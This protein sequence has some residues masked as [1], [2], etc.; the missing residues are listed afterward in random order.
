M[1]Y[2]YIFIKKTTIIIPLSYL[3]CII[4]SVKYIR[5]RTVA[6]VWRKPKPNQANGVTE[7][8]RKNEVNQSNQD[9]IYT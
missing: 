8:G 7:K 5:C 1:M 2:R 9:A 4:N 3:K 6:R